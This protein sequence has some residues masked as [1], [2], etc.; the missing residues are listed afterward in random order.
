M[1]HPQY[2]YVSN[3]LLSHF[4]GVP[5]VTNMPRGRGPHRD[6]EQLLMEPCVFEQCSPCAKWAWE[7]SLIRALLKALLPLL[8]RA[9]K[10]PLSNSSINYSK[11]PGDKSVIIRLLL[12]E[13]NLHLR[14][15]YKKGGDM[16]PIAQLRKALF[17]LNLLTL[18][19]DIET[20]W[21]PTSH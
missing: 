4:A 11:L 12:R 15:W 17:T 10:N 13:H 16:G 20:L 3:R 5:I 2:D 7:L 9:P 19:Y 6:V 1:G 21:N 18:N 14:T 8:S